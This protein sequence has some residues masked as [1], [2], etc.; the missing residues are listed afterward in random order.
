MTYP[1]TFLKH[2]SAGTSMAFGRLSIISWLISEYHLLRDR[3]SICP[4][5]AKAPTL[6]PAP[7]MPIPWPAIMRK[8]VCAESHTDSDLL[9]TAHDRV[10]HDSVFGSK[11]RS[12]ASA[13][14]GRVFLLGKDALGVAL[15]V[16][17]WLEAL[18]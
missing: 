2:L 13:G 4:T 10:G 5:A 1:E 8:T 11:S 12:L 17:V 14:L 15:S 6:N 9:C 3:G 7:A 18:L 16:R